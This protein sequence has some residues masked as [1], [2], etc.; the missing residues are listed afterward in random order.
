MFMRVLAV[1]KDKLFIDAENSSNWR[2]KT[3]LFRPRKGA[4]QAHSKT[5]SADVEPA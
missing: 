3:T 5:F 2:T 4:V 1:S